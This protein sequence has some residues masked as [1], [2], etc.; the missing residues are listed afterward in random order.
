MRR[1]F[2]LLLGFTLLAFATVSARA[3]ST[4]QASLFNLQ[5][6]AYPSMDAWLDV[7]DSAGNFVTGLTPAQIMLV[8]DS[9][10]RTPTTLE[11]LQPPVRFILALDPGATFA[12]QDQTAVTR[13]AKV[14]TAVKNWAD[15]HSD[16]LGDDLSLVATGTD[17]ATHL[18][19]TASFTQ[20]LSAY[21]PDL[22]STSPTPDTL[23]RALDAAADPLTQTGMKR[24]ILLIASPAAADAIPILDNLAARAVELQ[25][26]V[27]VWI[28]ASQSAFTN[29]QGVTTL[30]DLALRTGGQYVLFSGEEPLPGIETYLSPVRHTYHLTYPTAIV[31]SGSHT[32]AAQINMNGQTITSPALSFNLDVQPPNPILVVPPEQIVREAPDDKTVNTAAFQPTSQKLSIIIEFPDKHPR[33]LVRTA[34]YVDGTKVAEN[35]SEPFD[36]FTWDLT[37]YSIG[38]QHM[39]AVEAVDIMGLSK[40]SL[41]VPVL[42]AVLQPKLG[43]L[44]FLARNSLWVALGA[45]LIAGTVLGIVLAL[46]RRKHRPVPA[47]RRSRTD[48]VT[49]PIPTDAARRRHLPWGRPIKPSDAFL[50]R[51]RDDGQ[52]M[53]APPIP[54]SIPEMIFGSDPIQ[55]TR[56]LD[57]PSVSPLHA[58]LKLENGEYILSDEKSAAGTWV[59]YEPLTAPRRLQHG[60]IIHIGK[61]SYRFML[62][63]PPERPAPRVTPTKT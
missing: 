7:F 56:I 28:V 23:A 33:P 30:K 41:G 34:L 11:E 42:V 55:A 51:L 52:P 44:A 49:Q 48:P 43:P 29:N 54:V 60:D 21:N 35:I 50:V 12:L 10:S 63:K 38:S 25:A 26:R 59:N 2:S 36:Q 24:V 5:T 58:R 19:T 40:T 39:L 14:M 47:D 27:D 31:A 9:L 6:N 17:P 37:G 16:S 53:T 8:E 61:L 1:I 62:R 13:F 57:D 22:Q 20:A 32:L 3:Q 46:G 15:T 45:I 18:L 4:A